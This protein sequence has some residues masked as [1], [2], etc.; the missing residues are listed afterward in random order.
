MK[1]LHRRPFRRAAA[2]LLT[3][4]AFVSVQAPASSKAK[5]D[6]EA[7][8]TLF[9]DKGCA[10]C[11]GAALEGTKKAPPLA[12]IQKNKLWTPAK[13]TDQILNGGKKM[14]PFADSLSDQDVAQIVAYLHAK[15]RPVPPP[16]QAAD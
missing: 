16:A 13:M 9:R 12:D 2:L 5:A 11:H 1:I 7:G 3:T 6:E 15:H 4:L 8:A 14:P 10:H